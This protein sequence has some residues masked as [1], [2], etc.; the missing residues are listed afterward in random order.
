MA[1]TL[2]DRIADL[3]RGAQGA[4]GALVHALRT[5]PPLVERLA[6]LL[7]HEHPLVRRA[8]L[9]GCAGR[10]DPTLAAAARAYLADPLP[11]VRIDLADAI[12]AAP[13]PLDDALEVLLADADPKVRL[14]ATRAAAGRAALVS[15]LLELLDEDDEWL[16]RQTAAEG[17]EAAPPPRALGGLVLAVAEDDD[18]DVSK[19]AA[20][21]AE[22]VLERL[23]GWPDDA[24]APPAELLEKA[25]ER[26]EALGQRRFPRLAAWTR[27]RLAA[28]LDPA[29][30]R[31]FGVDLT[32]EAED[33]RLP[34]AHRVDVACDAVIET[35]TA[36][37]GGPRAVV[38]LGPPGSGKTAVAHEVVHRL[39]SHEGGAW[40]V[41]RVNPSDILA[42][43]A[44]LGEWQTKVRDLVEAVKAPRRVLLYVQ[45]L[46][47]LAH[48]GR[49]S[50]NDLNVATMLAPHVESGAIA[51]LGESTPE[52]FRTGLGDVASLR[53]L[54]VPVELAD[55]DAEETKAIL[56]AVRDETGAPMA[57]PDLDRLLDLAGM[58]LAGTAQPGRA[59]GLLRRVVEAHAGRPGSIRARDVLATLATSTGVPVDLLDDDTPLDLARVRQ[60]FEGRVMGQ[61][62][63]VSTVIDLVALVKAGLTDPG[64]PY[65]VLL[66]VG[67][68]GVGK[69]ELARALAELLFGDASR[70]VR[71]D[72]SEYATH[73]A[74]ERLLG[75]RGE[76]GLLTSAVRE[77]PFSVVL[78]DE[79]EKAHVN[80]FDLLLQVF[81]AGRL[82]DA[83]GVTADFRRTIVILTSNL[84]SAVPT[85][86]GVGFG[87]AGAVPPPPDRDHAVREVLRFFRPEFVNRLDHVVS[88]RPL[89]LET[90]EQI[91]RREVT[92]VLERGGLARRRIAVDVDPAVLALL[93]RHGYSPA[94]GARPL[95]RTV[96]RFVLLPLAHA[97]ARGTAPAG[98]LV[99][100]V[101]RGERVDLEVVPVDGPEA[102][103]PAPPPPASKAAV[104]DATR[105]RT[106][107]GA[108][109]ALEARAAP[110]AARKSTGLARS[111]APGFW[112]DRAAATRALD[113]V[114]R[115]EKVGDTVERAAR[116][117][118][119][120]VEAV[121]RPPAKGRASRLA[122]RLA[123]AARALATATSLVDAAERDDLG[124]AFVRV[125]RVRG[126]GDPL[127][128]VVAITAM[129]EAFAKRHGLDV[130]TLDDR[131]G[132]GAAEDVVVLSVAGAGARALLAGEAGF[133]HLV[134]R[135][136]GSGKRRRGAGRAWIRVEVVPA[137]D[138]DPAGAR[139]L[140]KVRSKPLK[141]VAGRRV[142]QPTLELSLLHEPARVAVTGVATGTKDAAVARLMPWLLARVAA[143][144]AP[145]DDA[146]AVVRR[147]L[148]APDARVVDRRH[149]TSSGHLDRVLAG[150]LELLLPT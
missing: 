144:G 146:A 2:D 117:A 120:V 1:Q 84:G 140:V 75:A 89:S 141:G 94:F 8:A 36:T 82:T 4:F 109:A 44:Y 133:H 33:G 12:G 149:G 128:G 116:E 142:K 20:R 83:R 92:R 52:A 150:E 148:L 46:A 11:E 40:R 135:A 7:A 91:A 131:G 129:L 145:R 54:F 132:D 17:L 122:D 67:P 126:E 77:R 71:F 138:T 6:A 13:W 70:L 118:R 96:E 21:I 25:V 48:A 88:F 143:A 125:A 104:A 23:G 119:A 101:A 28:G 113:D 68:T 63:A 85:E 102:D 51:I 55:A 106:L 64:R 93:L 53:R 10:P 147:Y 61:P 114:H 42:G 49:S 65:G 30:L 60:F 41:L 79:I 139:P 66:F 38:L 108:A 121:A 57:D 69:T 124:D 5:T 81:D 110:L 39:A 99:R 29:R 137:C 50:K 136:G 37:G 103:A 22:K 32:A 97:L 100:L 27:E 9:A 14:A 72:M 31:K 107:A 3:L 62:E 111:N 26:L 34:R 86:S 16:V 130:E 18:R 105:A 35:L 24:P 98:S 76:P 123:A 58:Y 134:R 112:K 56:R 47:E 95:K 90:T 15:R 127:D 87:A 74:F 115:L 19:A 43:T 59:V 73:D 78:F 45:N 80:A